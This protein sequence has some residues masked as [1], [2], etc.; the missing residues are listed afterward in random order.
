MLRDQHHVDALFSSMRI[1]FFT[2]T[3]IQIP[4]VFAE[5]NPQQSVGIGNTD[6]QAFRS[7]TVSLHGSIFSLHGSI[8]SLHGSIVSLHGSI[9]SLH[10]SIVS[11]HGSHCEPPRLHF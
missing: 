4:V 3:R 10:G 2:C 7:S 1:R 6:L 11:L 5:P 8:V 9:V